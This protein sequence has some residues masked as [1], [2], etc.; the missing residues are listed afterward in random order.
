MNNYIFTFQRCVT[1]RRGMD[2]L[3][4]FIDTLYTPLE[5]TCHTAISLIYTLYGSPLHTH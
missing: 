1:I 2:W 5:T 4:G 3:V